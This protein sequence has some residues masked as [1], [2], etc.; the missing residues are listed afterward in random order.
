M[1]HLIFQSLNYDLTKNYLDLIV[2][3]VCIMVVVSKVE[4]RKTVLGVFHLGY[5][6]QHGSGW[7]LLHSSKMLEINLLLAYATTVLCTLFLKIKTKP[8]IFQNKIYKKKK[9]KI[10]SHNF[11]YICC[12]EPAFPRLGQMIIDYDPPMKKLAEEFVPHS[13]VIYL[14]CLNCKKGL[15]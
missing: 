10:M 7:V 15:H 2:T 5:E 6:Y 9:K 11:K 3:Y 12:R 13:R 4:D 8:F 1:F 14:F